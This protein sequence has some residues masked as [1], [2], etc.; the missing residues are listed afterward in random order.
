VTRRGKGREQFVGNRF[1][2]KV[3]DHRPQFV[4]LVEAQSVVNGPQLARRVEKYVTALAVGV[5]DE[6]VEEHDGFEQG[7]IVVGEVEVVMIGIVLDE[8]LERAGTERPVAQNGEGDDAEAQRLADEVRGHLAQ[9]EGVFFKIPKRLFAFAGFVNG[10]TGFPFVMN[11][12]EKG[13]V[14]AERELSLEFDFAVL[15]RV[16][17][18]EVAGHGVDFTSKR[19]GADSAWEQ[20][21][22]RLSSWRGGGALLFFYFTN[23]SGFGKFPIFQS[24]FVFNQLFSR[25]WTL[26]L[27]GGPQLDL[28]FTL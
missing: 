28:S 25:P 26:L 16:L 27:I 8:L 7:L 21:I 3:P 17:E 13:V 14:R 20:D 1:T 10:L 4:I 5:V 9:G 24:R 18:W 22:T 15:K 6:Q 2:G 19:A 12:Y 23:K 11:I